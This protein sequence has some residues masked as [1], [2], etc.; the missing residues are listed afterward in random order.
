[1]VDPVA[2]G[3]LGLTVESVSRQLQA[4]W[5]GEVATD[6]RL[7]DRTI[8]V[9]VRYP[10]AFRRDPSRLAQMPVRSSDGKTVPIAGLARTT[11]SGSAP[12]LKRENLRQM[13]LVTGRLEE[14]DLGSA[15]A[16]VRKSLADL[17][18][19]VGY[20]VEIGGQYESQRQA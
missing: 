5:L 10:D 6:L 3:R 7:F 11:A 13:A 4:A 14:R 17:A 16:E 15:V 19:P 1:E 18:L 9:R 8:P 12:I 20:S 2:V